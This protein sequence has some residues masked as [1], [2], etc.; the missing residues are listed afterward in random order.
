MSEK[1]KRKEDLTEED[2][3]ARIFPWDHE[4][5]IYIDE[6]EDDGGEGKERRRG[7]KGEWIHPPDEREKGIRERGEG[8]GDRR[9]IN[10]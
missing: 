9:K 8:E 1:R 2:V 3:G 5:I 6:G 4:A 10:P 7:G